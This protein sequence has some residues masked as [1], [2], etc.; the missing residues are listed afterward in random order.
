MNSGQHFSLSAT[1]MRFVPSGRF[2]KGLVE[3]VRAGSGFVECW[4]GKDRV[5]ES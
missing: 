4:Q 5:S 3:N 1:R 2:A